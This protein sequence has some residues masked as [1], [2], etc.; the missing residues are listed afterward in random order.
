MECGQA[1]ARGAQ[2]IK[3]GSGGN[4]KRMTGIGVGGRRRKPVVTGPGKAAKSRKRQDWAHTH[5]STKIPKSHPEVNM[6]SAAEL[7]TQ[8]E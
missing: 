1:V 7:E 8:S 2:Q 3:N 4:E 6:P 5:I